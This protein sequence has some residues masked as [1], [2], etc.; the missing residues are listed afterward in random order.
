MRGGRLF[1]C[2]DV[3]GWRAIAKGKWKVEEDDGWKEY[4]L[5]EELEF[6]R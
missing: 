1:W 3:D 4:W 5:R 6:C 2:F